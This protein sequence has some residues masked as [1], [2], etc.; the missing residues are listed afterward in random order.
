MLCAVV[1]CS[2]IVIG[3]RWKGFV[4]YLICRKCGFNLTGID[5]QMVCPECGSDLRTGNAVCARS[6]RL[7]TRSTGF[8]CLVVLIVI[9]ISQLNWSYLGSNQFILDIKPDWMLEHD[10]QRKNSQDIEAALNELIARVESRSINQ[11]RLDRLIDVGLERLGDPEASSHDQQVWMRLIQ[12]AHKV[13]MCKPEKYARYVSRT[14]HLVV[15]GPPSPATID[16][17]TH[18]FPFSSLRITAHLPETDHGNTSD[19]RIRVVRV[20]LSDDASDMVLENSEKALPVISGMYSR[21]YDQL[22]SSKIVFQSRLLGIGQYTVH[23]EAEV[24]AADTNT[25]DVDLIR[26]SATFRILQFGTEFIR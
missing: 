4:N 6:R 17:A 22:F 19:V 11:Q 18:A 24:V 21:E 12:S 23:V 5:D 8:A 2:L 10:L 14:A 16:E 20:W 3:I 9:V 25:H 7:A 15:F 26:G 13:G 1:G